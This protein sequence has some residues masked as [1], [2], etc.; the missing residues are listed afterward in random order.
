MKRSS[1]RKKERAARQLRRSVPCQ[2]GYYKPCT[3]RLHALAPLV[4]DFLHCRNI[5]TAIFLKLAYFFYNTS[6]QRIYIHLGNQIVNFVFGKTSLDAK[7]LAEIW[8]TGLSSKAPFYQRQ[9]PFLSNQ[10]RINIF[11]YQII[12]SPKMRLN[13]QNYTCAYLLLLCP[14]Y[15]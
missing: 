11:L 3:R 4:V 5:T 8:G 6:E 14:C 12:F 2:A 7:H 1:W 9:L 15:G 13:N 10:Y